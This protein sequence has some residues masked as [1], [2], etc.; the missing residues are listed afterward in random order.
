MRLTK[1][2]LRDFRGFS[3]L[4]LEVPVSGPLVLAGVNGCG[5]SSVLD[6]IGA[7]ISFVPSFVIGKKGA[8]FDAGGKS[9][10]RDGGEV[11]QWSVDVAIAD[12]HVGW[13]MREFIDPP[14]QYATVDR[15]YRKPFETIGAGL[16]GSPATELPVLSYLHASSTRASGSRGEID[17]T[18]HSRLAC[19]SG[20]FDIEAE[21]YD[22]LEKWFVETENLENERKVSE[23]QLKLQLPSL[24]A[25]RRA[26]K[27]FL[28]EV[29]ADHL[30][31]LRAIRAQDHPLG[32]VAG[33]VA[34][35]K[36]ETPLFLDQ[37]SDGERRLLVL[38]A[39]LARRMA[40]ANPHLTDPLTS[41]GVA[42]VDE[43]EMHLHPLW[44]R[45]VMPALQAAFPNV[46]FIVSTHSPQVLASVPNESVIAIKDFQVVPGVHRVHGRDANAILEEE[47]GTPPRPDEFVDRFKRLYEAI[48]EEPKVARKLLKQLS[49]ELGKDDPE[50]TRARTLIELMGV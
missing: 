1:I 14:E 12:A 23:G 42:L 24:K 44:Q 8:L 46:Q 47:M 17:L 38:V 41:P 45:R 10:I 5:K 15:A 39:D 21:H 4:D 20:A 3:A 27:T 13:T 9:N 7:L 49:S 22:A 34:I 32:G 30:H 16:G 37:L 28:G 50:V 18:S 43:I 2:K 35:H 25:V 11:A 29:R 31:D 48:D 36:G 26:V 6:A 40:I 19:Y 33:R